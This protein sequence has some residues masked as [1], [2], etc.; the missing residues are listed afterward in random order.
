M[1]R[2]SVPPEPR[3][4]AGD[5][6][7]APLVYV[8]PTWEYKRLVRDLAREAAPDETELDALGAQGWELAGAFARGDKAHFYFKRQ[9]G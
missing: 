9:A 4:P 8:E 6:V 3:R 5:R 2:P 7:Q 1:D